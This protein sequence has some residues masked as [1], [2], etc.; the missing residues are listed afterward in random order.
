MARALKALDNVRFLCVCDTLAQLVVA[1][2]EIPPARVDN[3]GY[4][5]DVDFFTP[6]DQQTR[7]PLVAAIVTLD[8]DYAT[9]VQVMSSAPVKVRIVA[10]IEKVQFDG[11]QLPPNVALQKCDRSNLVSQIPGRQSYADASFVVVPLLPSFLATGYRAILE[12]KAMGKAVIAT[13]TE[14]HGDFIVDGETGY[15][16]R[17]QQPG[18]VRDRIEHLLTNPELAKQMGPRSRERV[19]SMFSLQAFCGRMRNSLAEAA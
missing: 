5:V 6:A 11:V 9:L 4:G 19:E 2:C 12:A 13:K 7:E 17:P 8:C 15:Y 3:V 18:D 10:Q 1:K 16:V 14:A